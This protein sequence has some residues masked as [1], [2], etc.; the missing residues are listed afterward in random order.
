M[1][2]A[3]FGVLA[4]CRLLSEKLRFWGKKAENSYFLE[5]GSSIT[6][7]S[8]NAHAHNN[9]F[10]PNGLECIYVE[11][12]RTRP[13]QPSAAF[14]PSGLESIPIEL[15]RTRPQQPSM[16]WQMPECARAHLKC[17]WAHLCWPV[18]AENPS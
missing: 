3:S 10:H 17:D 15:E 11:R 9:T 4:F 8:S 5:M 2:F 13:Q 1:C 12:E 6:L 16:P 7:L 14:H 18:Y